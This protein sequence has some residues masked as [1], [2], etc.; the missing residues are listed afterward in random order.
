VHIA[1]YS[2]RPESTLN[3]RRDSSIHVALLRLVRPKPPYAVKEH[4]ERF[5]LK[6]KPTPWMFEADTCRR[7]IE[8]HGEDVAVSVKV[9]SEGYDPLLE[10]RVMTEHSGNVGS[11]A[12]RVV[13]RMFMVDFDYGEFLK[14]VEPY[15]PI[16]RLAE[17]HLGLR[18][19]K[20]PT[21][22]E[23][24]V[25]SIIQQRIL[26]KLALKNTAK[27]VEAYGRR[28]EVEGFT[29]Y[30]FPS[31]ETL[32]SLKPEELKRV[33][34]VTR[35]KARTIVEVLQMALG[36][37]LPTLRDVDEKPLQVIEELQ[38]IRGV[39]TWTAELTVALCSKN[40]TVGPAGDLAVRR[41]FSR[42]YGSDR[43]EDV[44]RTLEAM[45]PYVGLVMYLL[46]IDYH[47]TE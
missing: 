14:A 46:S 38:E 19:T 29:H 40:F 3:S 45:K 23:T 10:L 7:L 18:P 41:G 1:I 17:R 42:T 16:R 27:L 4:L 11:E 13:E 47:K 9:A 34:G 30:G 31:P 26:L 37:S 15:E 20:C 35:F 12:L 36:G 2:G 44:R 8:V 21:V 43:E 22:Y 33:A 24:L 39:G 5:S 25:S 6:G 28:L 32:G